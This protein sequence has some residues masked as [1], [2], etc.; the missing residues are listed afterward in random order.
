MAEVGGPGGDQERPVHNSVGSA[1]TAV[2]ITNQY[3]AMTFRAAAPPGRGMIPHEVPEYTGHFVNR[4]RSLSY[5]DGTVSGGTARSTRI[6][7]LTGTRGI[8]KSTLAWHWLARMWERFPGGQLYVDLPSVDGAIDVALAGCLAGL[9]VDR[10]W[11][12]GGLELRRRLYRTCTAGPPMAVMVEDATEPAQVRSLVPNAAGSLVLVTSGGSLDELALDGATFVPVE[13]FESPYSRALLEAICGP[14][15]LAA[16]PPATD[17]LIGACD[18]LPLAVQVAAARI[19][20]QDMT[21]AELVS[22]L[23]DERRRLAGLSIGGREKVSEV[24]STTYEGLPKLEALAY[25]RCALLPG[26]DFTSAEAAVMT[27]LPDSRMRAILV[28]LASAGLVL[29]EAAGRYRMPALVRLH[30]RTVADLDED[31]T[32][33]V[34]RLRQVVLHYASRAAYADVTVL[35]RRRWADDGLRRDAPDNPFSGA[36]GRGRALKWLAVEQACLLAAQEMATDHGW[37]LVAARLGEALTALYLSHRHLSGWIRSGLRGADAAARAARPALEARLRSLTSRPLTDSGRLDEARRQLDAARALAER[38]GDAVL[39]GSVWE[40]TGRYLDRTD[41]PA[42]VTA[43]R[44]SLAFTTEAGERRGAALATYFLGS[45][46]WESGTDQA[47]ALEEL[48]RAD[49]E[50]EALGDGRMRGRVLGS[51]GHILAEQGRREEAIATLDAALDLLS[52]ADAPYYEAQVHER[53]ADLFEPTDAARAQR[54][55]RRALEN[56]QATN[57]PDAERLQARLSGS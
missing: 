35:E 11:I 25:R 23:D 42:A 13:Q 26:P 43:Y 12:A 22:E 20:R 45:A 15:R 2:Q 52:E 53:L 32:I 7:V 34:E 29:R 33:V 28:D 38:V 40:F 27:E 48:H 51:L 31:P 54:H 3:G 30:A 56:Y 55:L 37:D 46:L 14:D 21:V 16:D 24:F 17:R 41:P 9:G 10:E 1:G 47:A 50:F 44:R 18:G 5:L 39:L 19:V 4:E 6:V 36:D 8:G 49:A 57:G